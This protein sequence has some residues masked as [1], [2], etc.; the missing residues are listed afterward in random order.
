MKRVRRGRSRPRESG[1]IVT[2]DVNSL[3]QVA[4]HRVH[5][6]IFG[7]TVH[8]AGRLYLYPG[9]LEKEGV[10]YLGQSVV[11]VK[12]SLLRGIDAFLSRNGVDHEATLATLG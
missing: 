10:R 7:A 9:F 6:F 2:W 8:S 12:P 4:A 1:F 3:D 11:F 5:Y